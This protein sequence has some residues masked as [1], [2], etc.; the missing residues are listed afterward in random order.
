MIVEMTLLL[1]L[2]MVTVTCQKRKKNKVE[3]A[4]KGERPLDEN[5]IKI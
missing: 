1:L 2:K 5:E 3:E 4:A